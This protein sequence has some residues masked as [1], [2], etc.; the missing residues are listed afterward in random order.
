M[1]PVSLIAGALL[2]RTRLGQTAANIGGWAITIVVVLI[3]IAIGWSMLKGSI[4]DKHDL[5]TRAAHAEHG[6]EQTNK[7]DAADEDLEARDDAATDKLEEEATN[8]A[9]SDPAGAAKPV[10]PV[11]RSVHDGLR[12]NRRPNPAAP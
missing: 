3:L 11:S 4:I 5:E 1:F 6:L 7:A 2:K 9:H 8:A 12:N 10:G